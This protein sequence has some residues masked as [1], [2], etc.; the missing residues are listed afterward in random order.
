MRRTLHQRQARALRKFQL[1]VDRAIRAKS[2]REKELACRWAFV[3]A[4]VARSSV[5]TWHL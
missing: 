3:W 2:T 4:D 5:T 1:A